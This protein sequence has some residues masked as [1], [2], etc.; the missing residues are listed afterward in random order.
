MKLQICAVSIVA[1][2]IVVFAQ[3]SATTSAAEV[4]VTTPIP[5]GTVSDVNKAATTHV[6]VSAKSRVDN[7][8]DAWC[9]EMNITLGFV[10][11]KNSFYIKGVER[12]TANVQDPTFIKSRSLAYAKAYQNAVASYIFQKFGTTS[13][14]QFNKVFNDF[15]SGGEAASDVKSSFQRIA[16]KAAQLTEAQLDEGLRKLG[17]KPEGNVAAK[18]TL[19]QNAIIK[20][21]IKKASG[22][23]AG[24]LPVQTFEGWDENGKYAVGVVIRGGIETEIIAECLKNKAKPLL[25]RPESGMSVAEALPSDEE[26]VSQ[27]GVRMFFDENGTPALLSIGQWGSSYTGDDEDMEDAAMDHARDQAT[28][29][30]NDHLTMFINST[31]SMRSESQRGEEKGREVEAYS[32]GS[33]VE[34]AIKTSI[35]RRFQE[36]TMR[37]S[38]TAR[39]RALVGGFPKVITHPSSGQKIAVS[40]IVWSFDQYN[41]MSGIVDRPKVRQKP[42]EP[43]STTPGNRRG[44]TYDF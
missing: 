19:A 30:A 1:A 44:R 4:S 28:D 34:K 26:I 10:K 2:S 22:D 7:D 33:S 37:G 35:D 24:L 5:A 3:D 6:K 9:K 11:G 17:I 20:E 8:I 31:L 41:A 40:A 16:D 39:G 23:S 14:E 27:F 36:S 38:D 43:V 25:S 15:S 29:E 13:S 21:T 18:R 12:V 42:Q 32:D